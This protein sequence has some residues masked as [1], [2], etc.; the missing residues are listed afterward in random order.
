MLSRAQMPGWINTTW[1]DEVLNPT[2][3]QFQASE[4]A[5]SGVSSNLKL[6]RSPRLALSN[7]GSRPDFWTT[8]QIADLQLNQVTA[9]QLGIDRQVKQRSISDALL[10]I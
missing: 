9:S 4:Q 7:R 3:S 5:R 10:A 1:E 2:A 6:N 8:D